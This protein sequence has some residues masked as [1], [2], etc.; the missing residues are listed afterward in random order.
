MYR[1]K[2]GFIFAG[3]LL[4]I[5]LV[6]VDLARGMQGESLP[7]S[8]ENCLR[9][10]F[11]YRDPLSSDFMEISILFRITYFSMLLLIFLLLTSAL[12]GVS[13]R[14]RAM[15][16]LRF[17]SKSAFFFAAYKKAGIL[18]VVVLAGSAF[19]FFLCCALFC[20][21]ALSP[22][23]QIILLFLLHYLRLFMFF[24]LCVALFCFFLFK[25]G[26][27]P[28]IALTLLSICV[29]LNADTAIQ[30]VSLLAWG[31]LNASLRGLFVLAAGYCCAVPLIHWRLKKTDML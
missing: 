6:S 4:V 26:D 19:W 14:C 30:P 8:F 13:R 12:S 31:N 27:M 2:T 22:S 25:L 24:N 5:Q 15:H 20:G 16:L 18:S 3:M 10:C 9:F 21:T 28:G 1:K 17:G 23:M 7:V 29:L 11:L